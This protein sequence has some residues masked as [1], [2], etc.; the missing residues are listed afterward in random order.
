MARESGR[1]LMIE[2]GDGASSPAYAK[3]AAVRTKSYTVNRE[4]IDVTTDGDAGWR[5][6]GRDAIL[7]SEGSAFAEVRTAR[8]GSMSATWAA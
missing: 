7:D 2:R 3:I 1:D 4:P 8:L 6:T 5:E